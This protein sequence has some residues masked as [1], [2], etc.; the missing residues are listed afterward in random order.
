M[1]HKGAGE[2]GRSSLLRLAFPFCLSDFPS[3]FVPMKLLSLPFSDPLHLLLNQRKCVRSSGE[4]EESGRTAPSVPSGSWPSP[5]SLVTQR[6]RVTVRTEI[7]EKL[8]WG[9]RAGA[10]VEGLSGR[11]GEVLRGGDTGLLPR[12]PEDACTAY[13]LLPASQSASAV[14]LPVI[15]EPRA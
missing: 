11:R 8:R 3:A 12:P 1:D 5:E 4:L 10:G 15:P 13:S 7:K 2:E 6:Q 14:V 9:P